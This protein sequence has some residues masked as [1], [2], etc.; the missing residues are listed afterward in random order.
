MSGCPHVPNL[1]LLIKDNLPTRA[2][3]VKKPLKCCTER[4]LFEGVGIGS[5]A[6][7]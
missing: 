1:L 7:A 4:P 2:E 6:P 5:D 3:L